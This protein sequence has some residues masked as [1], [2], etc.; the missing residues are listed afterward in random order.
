MDSDLLAPAPAAPRKPGRRKSPLAASVLSFIIPGLGELYAGAVRRAAILG[1]PGVVITLWV[2]VQLLEGV[3]QF[4]LGLLD[5]SQSAALFAAI[6]IAGALRVVSV[7]D[8]YLLTARPGSRRGSSAGLVAVLVLAAVGIHAVAAVY[9]ASFW[10]A[11]GAIF[12]GNT[13]PATPGLLSS[14]SPDPSASPQPVDVFTGQFPPPEGGSPRITFLLVGADSGTGYNHALTDS[15]ILVSIDTAKKSVVMASIPRDFAQFPMYNGGSCG[16][17]INALM[18]L[19]AQNPAK[20]PDGGIGTLAKEIQFL[21]GVNIN[22]YAF[23]DLGGYASLIDAVGGVDLVNP[24]DIADSGYAFADGK[25]GFYLAAGKQHLD[26]RLG[27]A[28]VRSRHG[29]GGNDYERARRQ[30]LVLQ[31]IR[32]KLLSPAMLPRIPS[33]LD[34]LSKVIKTNYPAN[35]INTLVTLGQQ[36]PDSAITKTVLGPTLYAYNPPMS[37]TNGVWLLRPNVA[38]LKRWSVKMFGADSAFYQQ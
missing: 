7:V 26:S 28:F 32:E 18:T 37:T 21:L 13:P 8:S 15:Q 6:I 36:I 34:A 20:Y 4:A 12:T 30:Q 19:A 3:T 25:I 24:S 22:Y 27:T 17:K 10:S 9:A 38:A 14:Q 33:I 35:E 31:A 29:P 1:I 2:L 5:Q 11:G 23:I 16:C